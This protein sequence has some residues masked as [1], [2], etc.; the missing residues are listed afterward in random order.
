V[1]EITTAAYQS[2]QSS[3]CVSLPLGDENHLL[4]AAD[5]QV[6]DGLLD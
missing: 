1:A 5:E 2:A 3:D 6:I 4:I